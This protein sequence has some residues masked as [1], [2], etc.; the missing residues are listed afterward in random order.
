MLRRRVRGALVLW[1]IAALAL[2]ALVGG[3]T[4]AARAQTAIVTE[5]SV[6]GWPLGITAGPDGNVWFTELI[7]NRI[8]RI[9]PAGAVTEFS[10]GMSPGKSGYS[11]SGPLGIA[12]GPDGNLW[13]TRGMN[14]LI[15]RITPAGA[16]SE[17]SAGITPDSLAS[18]ITAGP[19]GNLWFTEN[20]GGRIGRITPTG[21]V[22]EF[23]A[24]ITP[25]Y[26]PGP[27]TTG[28]DG[29]LWFTEMASD[30]PS[31]RVG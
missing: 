14:N 24:G 22:T 27:I 5:F 13:F 11:M 25:G 7:G 6:R 28:P 8:G 29:N 12:T 15:G 17:F 30:F 31:S 2:A 21:V 3:L 1:G 4:P 16:V 18:G 20:W 10:E 9:T 23:A 26:G 19:D